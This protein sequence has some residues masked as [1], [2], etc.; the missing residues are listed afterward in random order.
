MNDK[1]WNIYLNLQTAIPYGNSFANES[2][3]GGLVD[4]GLD[5]R[6]LLSTLMPVETIKNV[7]VMG[8]GGAQELY[9]MERTFYDTTVH[10][11]TAHKPESDWINLHYPRFKTTYGDMH[12]TPYKNDQFNFV[13]SSN[14][15]EHALSPYIALME[16]RRIL[17]QPG[18]VVFVLP[19]FAGPEG[20]VGP[21]HIQ[22]LDF[23]VWGELL[24][25][26]GY[27]LLN[28]EEFKGAVNFEATY[29]RYICSTVP[30]SGP[31]QTTMESLKIYKKELL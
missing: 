14:V 8:P 29:C 18:W 31:H 26:T 7:L 1:L 9:L 23:N 17:T 2:T 16:C 3:S 4:P 12:D 5:F 11:L 24:K 20:G 27:Q 28:I 25:K 22:C 15:L 6:N 13:F 19:S 21:Y 10:G 30:L